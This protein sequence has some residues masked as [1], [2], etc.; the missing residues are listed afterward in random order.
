MQESMVKWHKYAQWHE[1]NSLMFVLGHLAK[2][3]Q[4][5][6]EGKYNNMKGLYKQNGV[7]WRKVY[8]LPGARSAE[9]VA[10]AQTMYEEYRKNNPEQET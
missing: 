8:N 10:R 1:D 7:N 2:V 3:L 5:A 6:D 9:D 4:M